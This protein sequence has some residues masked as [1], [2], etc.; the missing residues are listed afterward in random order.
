[1]TWPV[2]RSLSVADPNPLPQGGW[3]PLGTYALQ[4]L[5]LSRWASQWVGADSWISKA[6][7]SYLGEGGGAV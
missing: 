7:E 5:T 2:S 3:A 6:S 4:A 1:M